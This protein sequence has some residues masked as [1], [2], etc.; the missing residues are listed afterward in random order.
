[1]KEKKFNQ[2]VQTATNTEVFEYKAALADPEVEI[3]CWSWEEN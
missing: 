2:Y 1:M 3:K